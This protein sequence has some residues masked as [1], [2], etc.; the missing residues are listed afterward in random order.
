[1]VD[2]CIIVGGST[3]TLFVETLPGS[4]HDFESPNFFD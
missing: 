4:T 3:G 2:C 1:V